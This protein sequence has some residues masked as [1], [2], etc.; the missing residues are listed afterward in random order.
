[1][2]KQ[3]NNLPIFWKI[4]LNFLTM[5]LVLVGFGIW[6]YMFSND[7]YM[8]NKLIIE[9]S[10]P[11]AQLAEKMNRDVIQVQQWL[12]DISATRGLDGLDDGFKEAEVSYQ[13]L[14]SGLAKFEEMYREEQDSASL[15]MIKDLKIKIDNY[16]VT[17]QNMA[18]AYVDQG[19]AGGNKMMSSF[20]SAAANL[21]N[22]LQPFVKQQIDELQNQL[23]QMQ[24][25]AGTLQTGIIA[26]CLIASAFIFILGW[27]LISSISTPLG[28]TVEMIK[29]LEKGHLNVRLN[30]DRRD[31]IGQMADTMDNFAESMQNEVVGSLQSLAQG[32]LTYKIVPRDSEDNLRSAIQQVG[33]D[34][35]GIVSEIQMAGEQITSASG[36]VS[37]ASQGLSQT[38]TETA[39]SMEEISSTMNE[40]ASQT[41]QSAESANQANH[42][43]GEASNAAAQGGH[44]ME[45]MINA[46]GEIN[47]AGQNISKIIKVIDEIAFQTNLLALNAAVEAARAGQHGKGFAVVA[48]EVRNLAAR[49][50]KAASETAELIEGSVEKTRNGTQIAEQTS[51]SLEVIVS[52]INK[53]TDLVAEIADSSNQQA[54]G[55]SQ[56]NQGLGQIDIAIQGNTAT[57][58]ES[59]AAAEQLS[60]QSMRMKQ[61]LERFTL[62]GNQASSLS[63]NQHNNSNQNPDAQ[64]AW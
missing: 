35:N 21:S 52:A 2:L 28:K 32:D 26:I 47:E 31:E 5:L 45:S 30:L 42:L 8:G 15:Q 24:S 1:M 48:E 43:A 20:D 54:Q 33:N 16:Y 44:H 25:M 40:I 18:Q 34:L 53:M 56:V 22:A 4:S 49:S 64:I 41:T 14:L 29:T 51:S 61:M 46:M 27:A 23:S 59:A 36:Q 9:E 6:T 19:P 57:A 38:A 12:T 50:A 13:S 7:V 58:E 37:D 62:N 55:I 60:S 11:F 39:A 17:G 10:S 3:L 63:I